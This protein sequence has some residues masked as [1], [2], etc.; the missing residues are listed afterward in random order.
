MSDGY[1]SLSGSPEVR[2]ANHVA[3]SLR[4]LGDITREYD[5]SVDAGEF[6]AARCMIEAFYVH[7]RLLIEF[8]RVVKPR[9]EDLSPADFG[10]E[11]SP[12]AG[13]QADT[14]R[15][16]WNDA[17]KHVVHFGRE[18]IPQDADD[19][20]AINVGGRH[21]WTMAGQVAEMFHAFQTKLDEYESAWDGGALIPDLQSQPDRWLARVRSEQ[22]MILGQALAEVTTALEESAT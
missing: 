7:L 14:L 19:L 12:P 13:V 9:P 8:L 1:G 20:A 4:M 5:S 3:Y 15:G 10:V 16:Y 22:A 2:A 17:S 6:L 21:W 18:R 11:W